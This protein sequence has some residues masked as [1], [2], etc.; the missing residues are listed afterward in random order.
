MT[1][2]KQTVNDVK[3]ALRLQRYHGHQRGLR[4]LHL[5]GL[6]SQRTTQRARIQ[7][8]KISHGTAEETA[9]M[10]PGELPHRLGRSIRH[11]RH[12]SN[13]QRPQDA[14]SV[15]GKSRHVKGELQ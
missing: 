14:L 11:N 3:V 15:A 7:C 8:K 10:V 6:H 9:E 5:R 13:L 12:R 4:R 1:T 2:Y